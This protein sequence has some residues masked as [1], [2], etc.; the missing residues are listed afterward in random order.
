M[1]WENLRR[2]FKTFVGFRNLFEGYMSES[3]VPHSGKETSLADFKKEGGAQKM[4]THL[5]QS[6]KSDDGDYEI[7]YHITD[8]PG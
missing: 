1:C 5:P 8:T 4:C 6:V 7:F 3:F 2:H